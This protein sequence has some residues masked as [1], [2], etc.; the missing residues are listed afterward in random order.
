[1]ETVIFVWP[2]FEVSETLWLHSSRH[3]FNSSTP[4]YRCIFFYS[5]DIVLVQY[6]A[7][8]H[9]SANIRNFHKLLCRWIDALSFDSKTFFCNCFKFNRNTFLFYSALKF[10]E[11]L[12]RICSQYWIDH[13]Q[14]MASTK[15]S[16]AFISFLINWFLHKVELIAMIILTVFNT[17]SLHWSKT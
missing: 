13:F 6:F 1:M 5:F 8:R 10:R 2:L 9:L 16:G 17:Q 7:V 3:M 14:C 12:N 11:S 4:L 15:L